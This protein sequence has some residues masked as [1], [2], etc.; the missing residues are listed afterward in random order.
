MIRT[1]TKYNGIHFI[2]LQIFGIPN[3][4]GGLKLWEIPQG[5][6]NARRRKILPYKRFD[7]GENLNVTSTTR[8]R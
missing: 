5:L 6:W 7:S 4:L 2:G 3:F 1:V 8:D